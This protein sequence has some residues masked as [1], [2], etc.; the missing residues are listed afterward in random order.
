MGDAHKDDA[1][2]QNDLAWQIATD[3]RIKERDLALAET[4]AK[5][6]NDATKGENPMILD[7]LARVK[8]MQGNKEEAIALQE[9]AVKHAES[10]QEAQYQKSLDEYKKGEVAKAENN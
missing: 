7:T 5:R 6:A 8:F 9:K 1:M 3:R 2:F 4:L 10:G